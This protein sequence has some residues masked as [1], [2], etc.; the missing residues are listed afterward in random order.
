MCVP[1]NPIFP[2]LL[3]PNDAQFLRI[4]SLIGGSVLYFSFA[5]SDGLFRLAWCTVLLA[6][7]F[8]CLAH[9]RQAWLE[10]KRYDLELV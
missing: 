8:Q 5:N 2:V 10:E 1:E 9:F 6:K 7:G 4:F 3:F